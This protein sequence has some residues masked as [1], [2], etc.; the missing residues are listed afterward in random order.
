MSRKRIVATTTIRVFA[1][2]DERIGKV[3]SQLF[4]EE[5]LLFREERKQAKVK[6]WDKLVKLVQEQL[7]VHLQQQVIYE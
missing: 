2:D 5:Q 7:P 3:A 1:T 6:S 4:H